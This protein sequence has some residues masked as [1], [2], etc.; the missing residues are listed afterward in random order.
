MGW[1]KGLLAG[2]VIV[3]SANAASADVLSSI[4]SIKQAIRNYTAIAEPEATAEQFRNYG[5]FPPE[6][7]DSSKPLVVLIHGVDMTRTD[8]NPMASRLTAAGLQVA[9]FCYPEDQ[10]IADD[11]QFLHDRI[12]AIRSD[13]ARLKINI[14]SFSM[15]GLVARGYVEGDL[16]D[17]NVDRLILIAPPNHGSSWAYL[18][19]AAKVREQAYLMQ[20]DP[21]WKPTW[22]ITS[23][24]CEAGRD[25]QPDSQFLT[26][27]NKLPRR[28]GVR[29]TIIEGDQH[30]VQRIGG[31]AVDA[32]AKAIP[33]PVAD[34]DAGQLF[35]AVLKLGSDTIKAPHVDSDGPVSL[36]SAQLDGVTDVVTVHA[37]HEAMIDDDVANPPA[38]WETVHDRL[39]K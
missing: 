6:K 36:E 16:Y 8:L 3:A 19:W 31:D 24:L 23:G 39:A 9:C 15:G 20:Y 22:F 32:A 27:L 25:M 1:L 28:A 5:L 30:I 17:G 35:G 2:L 7:I 14:V 13:H 29:Y 18:E 34:T 11:V 4:D 21:H 26:D 37:D 33:K 12:S 38:S 10:P